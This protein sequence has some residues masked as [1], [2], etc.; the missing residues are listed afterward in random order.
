MRAGSGMSEKRANF[1]GRFRREDMLEL[2]RLLLDFGFAVHGK[3]IGEEA[4]RQSM[5]PDDA[6]GTLAP[7]RG[8]F[9]D[10]CAVSRGGGHR[11]QCVMAGI[12][13]GLMLVRLGR[14]RR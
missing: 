12:H 11:L 7:A 13:K 5:T 1:V 8:E 3:A 2:A 9:D 6:S 10:H 14:V 4:L